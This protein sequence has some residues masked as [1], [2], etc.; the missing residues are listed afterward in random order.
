MSWYR[1]GLEL[2]VMV[3]ASSLWCAPLSAAVELDEDAHYGSVIASSWRRDEPNCSEIE[4]RR[5][6]EVDLLAERSA[7]VLQQSNLVRQ[8]NN[9][10]AARVAD[11]IDVIA[12]HIASNQ[13]VLRILEAR[14]ARFSGRI[15]YSNGALFLL[16]QSD[17]AYASAPDLF[18]NSAS[19]RLTSP[20]RAEPLPLYTAPDS[21]DLQF[22][23]PEPIRFRVGGREI[24]LGNGLPP[25]PF[26]PGA[27]IT[28]HYP[29][30]GACSDCDFRMKT[31]VSMSLPMGKFCSGGADGTEAL[32]IAEA[33][34]SIPAID[35]DEIV[36]RYHVYTGLRSS[37]REGRSADL[38]V[39]LDRLLKRFILD[40]MG[41]GQTY[42]IDDRPLQAVT[43]GAT[44]ISRLRA[45]LNEINDGRSA[46]AQASIDQRLLA[47]FAAPV[48]HYRLLDGG[49]AEFVFDDAGRAWSLVFSRVGGNTYVHEVQLQGRVLYSAT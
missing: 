39:P 11:R 40:A 32:L 6:R 46:A 12:T 24:S 5:Q 20:Y 37:R 29:Q 26:V 28:F 23:R 9:D 36:I 44:Q 17:V 47:H 2:T 3:L 35:P 13:A 33:R 27:D 14:T 42:A 1:L 18:I 22:L 16:G 30:P 45:A 8:G 41:T 25:N 10:E 7:L 38:N 15:P 4:H 48:A 21:A 49:L 34:Y 31:G 19:V 43:T